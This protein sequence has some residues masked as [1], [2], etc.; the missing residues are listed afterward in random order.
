MVSLRC[1][2][3]FTYH[4][5]LTSRIVSKPLMSLITL[6]R[7]G[8]GVQMRAQ[9]SVVRPMSGLLTI[10]LVSLL[11]CVKVDTLGTPCEADLD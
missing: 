8:V 10:L 1:L 6:I 9:L 7:F 5:K 4:N 3:T 2:S 11:W